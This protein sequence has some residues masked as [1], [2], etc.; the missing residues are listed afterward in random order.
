M[1]SLALAYAALARAIEQPRAL[2]LDLTALA[3]WLME[4]NPEDARL[5]LQS[6][7]EY[8]GDDA[9]R[10]LGQLARQ[11]GDWQLALTTWKNL[12]AQGCTDSMERLAKYHEH[13]SKDLLAA[14]YYSEMLPGEDAKHE[15]RRQRLQ[16]KL[17]NRQ[18]SK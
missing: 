14:R 16:R 7:A 1:I 10:L 6:N 13:V 11:T 15:H 18:I 12:A 9:K 17:S 5:L 2:E 8:L 3:R 4:T